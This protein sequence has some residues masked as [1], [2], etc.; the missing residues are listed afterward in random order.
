VKNVERIE[1]IGPYI[2][3]CLDQALLDLCREHNIPAFYA[4]R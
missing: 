2:V 3:A 1:N 4:R